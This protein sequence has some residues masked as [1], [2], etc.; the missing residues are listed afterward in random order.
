MTINEA[1]I[2]K[3]SELSKIHIEESELEFYLKDITAIIEFVEQIQPVDTQG[4][5]PMPYPLTTGH[6]LRNDI[7]SEHDSQKQLSAL[8]RHM[9]ADMYQVPNVIE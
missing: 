6:A 2:K 3:I 9:E 5:E 4:I 1:D 7:I 8:S